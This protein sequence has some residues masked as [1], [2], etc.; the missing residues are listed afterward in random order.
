LGWW[1]V[2]IPALIVLEWL[3]TVKVL[4]WAWPHVKCAIL[5]LI[6]AVRK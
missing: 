2:L 6:G 4:R 1:S 5:K 3:V